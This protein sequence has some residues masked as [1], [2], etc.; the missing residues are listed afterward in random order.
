MLLCDNFTFTFNH[1]QSTVGDIDLC[2]GTGLVSYDKHI[3]LYHMSVDGDVKHNTV[4]NCTVK[5][6]RQSVH[7]HVMI[8]IS[9]ETRKRFGNSK[10]YRKE[11][12][13]VALLH[14]IGRGGL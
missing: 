1:S 4:C 2:C 8:Q 14:L 6:A 3:I 11:T 13:I 7:H 10:Y 5:H 12:L 9:L